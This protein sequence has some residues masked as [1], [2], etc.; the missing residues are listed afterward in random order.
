L[1]LSFIVLTTN[2]LR[3]IL[4]FFSS[5]A[6]LSC[7]VSGLIPLK[8]YKDLTNPENIKAELR[9]VGGVYGFINI[10]DG[11]QYIGSSKEIYERFTDHIKGVSTN[12]MLQRSISKHGITSFNFVIY[13]YHEDPAVILTDMETKVIPVIHLYGGL[14]RKL[15]F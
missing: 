12:I 10:K 3:E 15:S 7:Y 5:D 1:T 8:V 6:S 11:K 14:G 4:L 9:K 13:Y 2:E